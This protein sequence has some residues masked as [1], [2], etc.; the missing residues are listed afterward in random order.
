MMY[1]VLVY[2]Y[3]VVDTLTARREFRAFLIRWVMPVLVD[4][5]DRRQESMNAAH[6]VSRRSR[7]VQQQ[8]G[9]KSRIAMIWISLKA[10][11]VINR[12]KQGIFGKVLW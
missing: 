5:A 8:G 10:A 12:A 11:T 6:W 1:Q 3:I 4:K 2:S 9:V 7:Q